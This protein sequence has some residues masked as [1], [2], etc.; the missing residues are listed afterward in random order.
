MQDTSIFLH[1]KNV[2]HFKSPLV[3]L[4]NLQKILPSFT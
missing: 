1:K 4:L 2:L 3:V